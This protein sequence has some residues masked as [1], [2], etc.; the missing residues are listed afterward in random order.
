[1]GI[2]SARV[3]VKTVQTRAPHS[4]VGVRDGGRFVDARRGGGAA[5]SRSY[6]VSP[7]WWRHRKGSTAT[8]G[9]RSARRWTRCPGRWT[10]VGNVRARRSTGADFSKQPPGACRCCRWPPTARG[11]NVGQRASSAAAIE[12]F[13][14]AAAYRA[15]VT[16]AAR[17][18]ASLGRALAALKE[19]RLADARSLLEQPGAVGGSSEARRVLGLVYWAESE[20]RQEHRAVRGGHPHQPRR[21]ASPGWR[22]CL[23]S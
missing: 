15:L 17:Q 18:T 14:R 4:R 13:R 2:R 12:E 1:M 7:N 19:G 11:S 8:K 3:A 9:R 16:G 22:C 5:P 23:E 20:V 6:K 21:R 10:R